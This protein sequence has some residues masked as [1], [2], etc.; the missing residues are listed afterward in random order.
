MF[1][2]NCGKQIS[3]GAK[4]CQHCGAPQPQI[5]VT[6]VVEPAPMTTPSTTPNSPQESQPSITSS[7]VQPP[8]TRQ[9][10]SYVWLIPVIAIAVIALVVTAALLIVPKILDQFDRANKNSRTAATDLF[11]DPG[12][13]SLYAFSPTY[14]ASRLGQSWDSFTFQLNGY[15]LT[16]PC[17]LD[18]LRAADVTLQSASENDPIDPRSTLTTSC[19]VGQLQFQVKWINGSDSSRPLSECPAA[20]IWI[21]GQDEG[22][23]DVEL[24]LPGGIDYASSTPEDLTNAYSNA[25]TT[26][27]KENGQQSLV[28]YIWKSAN[29]DWLSYTYDAN[30]G[31][32]PLISL[33]I[34]CC[35]GPTNSDMQSLSEDAEDVELFFEYMD[36]TGRDIN[37]EYHEM[38]K[39]FGYKTPTPITTV[40][41]GLDHPTTE[42]FILQEDDSFYLL[43]DFASESDMLVNFVETHVIN[44]SLLT[45][46]ERQETV[47]HYLSEVAKLEDLDFIDFDFRS[48]EQWGIATIVYTELDQEEHWHEMYSLGV[49]DEEG[50]CFVSG[51]RQDFLA[52]GFIPLYNDEPAVFDGELNPE[53]MQLF[54]DANIQPISS[55]TSMDVESFAKKDEESDLVCLEFGHV[56]DQVLTLVETWYYTDV[57]AY[58]ESYLQAL[59][60]SLADEVEWFSSVACASVTGGYDNASNFYMIKYEFTDL[61]DPENCQALHDV[62]F[63]TAVDEFSLSKCEEASLADGFIKKWI[64][65]S[66]LSTS[67]ISSSGIGKYTL[68]SLES[69]FYDAENVIHSTD[70]DENGTNME[71]L[72]VTVEAKSIL[73][74]YINLLQDDKFGLELTDTGHGTG[75]LTTR[76]YYAFTF[77]DNPG[78]IEEI[79][80]EYLVSIYKNN[81]RIT[82]NIIIEVVRDFGNPSMN[83]YYPSG[84]IFA[85]TGDRTSSTSYI[86]KEES[87]EGE[88]SYRGGS[89]SDDYDS[90]FS[91]G[92]TCTF[93]GGSGTRTCLTCGG[94]GYVTNYG[95]VPRYGSGSGG[96]YSETKRCPNVMCHDGKVDCSYCGGDGIR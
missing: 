25:G 50:P 84:V 91:R 56:G 8:F 40:Q 92:S 61:D 46:D 79:T 10:K 6:Q 68:P 71:K 86:P 82:G 27:I 13:T 62:G 74:E 76:D 2:H 45:E 54:S 14:Q 20:A 26:E 93:C 39:P 7:N 19:Q 37:D 36:N 15:V 4:F 88:S 65:A 57:S 66:T 89:S 34:Q 81:K 29:N 30:N 48:D 59:Q 83:I 43:F 80:M 69:F 11:E 60:D 87:D 63:F 55:I 3:D 35:T 33:S 75:S 47:D 70:T 94:S 44:L 67:T 23:S 1:C 85:D 32:N 9:H 53:Y 21:D 77:T 24:L 18:D 42:R 41:Q 49:F 78:D 28:S 73:D 12:D 58:D 95:S 5:P 31:E 72:F 22:L 96:S 16:L 64:S 90:S 52:E 51:I 38:L 17:G